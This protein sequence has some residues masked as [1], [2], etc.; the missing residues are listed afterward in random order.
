MRKRA[1]AATSAVLL[2]AALSSCAA[3]SDAAPTG[4][5]L[6]AFEPLVSMDAAGLAEHLVQQGF[7]PAD[8]RYGVDAFR[9]LYR[10]TD[11]AGEPTVASGV[12]AFPRTDEEL[13][14][15]V[16]LHGTNPSRGTAASIVNSP[17]RAAVLLFAGTGQAA[18]APDYAGLGL[19][20]GEPEYMLAAPTVQTSLDSMRATRAIAE[21]RG[22]ELDGGVNV[23][24]FSQGGHASVPLGKAIQDDPEYELRAV[25]AVAGPHD[26]AGT[27]LPAALDGR[28]DPRSAV[29]YLGYFVTS[30]NHAY[31]LY[32]SPSEAFRAPYDQT[33]EALFD[34]THSFPEIL[35]GLPSTPQELLQPEM[36]QKLSHP[37]GELAEAFAAND[38]LCA[39]W[40]PDVPVR[41][42]HGTEDTDVP[43]ANSVRCQEALGERA[44]LVDVGPLDH[45]GAAL[46][47]IPQLA[48]WFAERG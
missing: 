35:Q 44:E 14:L 4:G 34:G 12:A 30:W 46:A 33:A 42:H 25:G 37:T 48:S 28:V 31:H 1:F 23:A 41:L 26:I 3:E 2:T 7:A 15:T 36:L 47:S 20:L 40:A 8:V 11:F 6:L 32:D 17:D 5:E 29:V 45:T 43:F 18:T 16:Y 22:A 13:P 10:T 39:Q 27:E 24:G 19:G 9:Y 21:Q 38:Q